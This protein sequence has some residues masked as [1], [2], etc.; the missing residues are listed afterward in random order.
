MTKVLVFENDAAFAQELQTEL[1]ARSFAVTVVDDPSVG[2]QAAAADRPDLILLA[3]ELPRMS[4]FSVCGKVKRDNNLKDVPLIIMSTDATEETFEQHKRLRTH[5]D[6][7]LHKPIAFADLYQ[8]ISALLG[9]GEA[10]PDSSVLID[11]DVDFEIDVE[12]EAPEATTEISELSAGPESDAAQ[13]AE[14]ALGNLLADDMAEAPAPMMT[15]SVGASDADAGRIAELEATIAEL[16]DRAEQAEAK[17]NDYDGKMRAAPKTEELQ[18]LQRDLEEARAKGGSTAREFLELREQLNRKDKEMLDL[19]DQLTSRDKDLLNLRDTNLALERAQ[20]DSGDKLAELEKNLGELQ[21]GNEAL[22]ADKEQAAKRADDYKKR[23]D[24]LSGEM[25]TLATERRAE[26]EKRAEDLAAAAEG[27]RQQTESMLRAEMEAALAALQ[28]EKDNALSQAEQAKN[29]ELNTQREEMLRLSAD[30]QAARE[31]ELR[32]E[33]D[34]TL[35]ALHRANETALQELQNTHRAAL[36]QTQ[37]EHSAA[38]EQAAAS[39]QSALE[40]TR[41]EHQAL[42]DKANAELADVR[43]RHDALQ[44]ASGQTAV[45][46][47]QAKEALQAVLTRLSELG[48]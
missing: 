36:A 31:Q 11:D 45:G 25:E 2:L 42:V 17:L 35:A 9:A 27:A 5:A 38:L 12:D 28:S 32:D 39:H 14:Q 23:N 15:T 20:A 22:K 34:A 19:R 13:F 8:H 46:L 29:N 24:K 30:T 43:Q 47:E 7:Y 21:R 4:G 37:A 48:N 18:K 3:V 44:V 33:H 10:Q 40:Q 1:T 26:R 16:T 41:A 6:A